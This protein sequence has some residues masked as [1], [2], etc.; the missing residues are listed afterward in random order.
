[1]GRDSFYSNRLSW[2]ELVGRFRGNKRQTFHH[3]PVNGLACFLQRLEK[4]MIRHFFLGISWN[5]GR[6][7]GGIPNIILRGVSPF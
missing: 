1:L 4:G 6:M 5:L 3:G 7:G 2:L